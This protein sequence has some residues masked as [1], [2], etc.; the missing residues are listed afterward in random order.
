V[1]KKAQSLSVEQATDD[2]TYDDGFFRVDDVAEAGHASTRVAVV[3]TA[4]SVEHWAVGMVEVAGESDAL[5]LDLELV[6]VERSRQARKHPTSRAR[7]VQLGASDTH[8]PDTP[9]AQPSASAGCWTTSSARCSAAAGRDLGLPRAR[10]GH[11]ARRGAAQPAG[12][13]RARLVA[14]LPCGGVCAPDPPTDAIDTGSHPEHGVPT[15]IASR[16]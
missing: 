14:A 2:L 4:P 15:R 11:D 1:V 5:A 3:L 12:V 7:Q 10:Q 16:R 8:H 6:R 9:S 13:A